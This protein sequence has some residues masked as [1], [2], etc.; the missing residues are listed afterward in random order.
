MQWIVGF[1]F[2]VFG[3]L[4]IVINRRM[5]EGHARFY[6]IGPDWVPLVRAV[7]YFGGSVFFVLGIVI[8]IFAA[9]S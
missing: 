3:V 2:I 8:V 9:S 4:S 5:A 7:Y 1:G 6:H